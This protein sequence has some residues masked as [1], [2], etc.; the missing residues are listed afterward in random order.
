MAYKDCPCLICKDRARGTKRVACQTGCE[1]KRERFASVLFGNKRENH[2]TTSVET[3]RWTQNM[4]N[5]C[6]ACAEL[7]C[8]GICADRVC[9]NREYQKMQ[10]G[11]G[12][13]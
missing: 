12:S 2:K 1:K 5:P 4:T 10:I 6:K 7:F 9:Y 13:R 11:Y 3:K 8:M